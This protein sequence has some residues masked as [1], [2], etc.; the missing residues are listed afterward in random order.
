MKNSFQLFNKFWYIFLD[1]NKYFTWCISKNYQ[2]AEEFYRKNFL[3]KHTETIRYYFTICLKENNSPI[4]YAAISG[5][6]RH[7]F[8]YGFQ[9]DIRARYYC[10]SGSSSVIVL[11]HYLHRFFDYNT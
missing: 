4:G 8:G 3:S 7:D 1:V 6:D 11:M 2:E 9:K 5:D 10:S